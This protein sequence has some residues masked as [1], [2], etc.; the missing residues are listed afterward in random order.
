MPWTAQDSCEC[1]SNSPRLSQAKQTRARQKS[2][3]LETTI[4]QWR[5]EKARESYEQT[6]RVLDK[7]TLEQWPREGLDSLKEVVRDHQVALAHHQRELTQLMRGRAAA[8]QHT[9]AAEPER[10]SPRS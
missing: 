3:D 4:A 2:S 9:N 10:T 5:V 8:H 7:A 1:A 6:A